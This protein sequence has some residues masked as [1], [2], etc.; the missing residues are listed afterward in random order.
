MKKLLLSALALGLATITNAQNPAFSWVNLI[1][2]D[3][4]HEE[5]ALDV[6]ITKSKNVITV[7]SIYQGADLNPGAGTFTSNNGSYY[8]QVVNSNGQFIWGTTFGH[9]SETFFGYN[10]TIDVDTLGNIY[11][12][13]NVKPGSYDLDFG[14][15]VTTYSTS[16][17]KSLFVAKY[18]SLGNLI[19]NQTC[20]ADVLAKSIAVSK[21]G[22]VAITG[23]YIGS[24]TLFGL[25]LTPSPNYNDGYV[26]LL[27]ANTG[28]CTAVNTWDD[29]GTEGGNDVIFDNV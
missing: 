28:S 13:A 22:K 11:L 26:A 5:I 12:A 17:N 1:G 25:T 24:P 3:E 20:N 21:N 14:A 9:L 27:D 15:G 8:I 6:A 18:D 2:T 19:W 29:G 23:N 10:V 7:G 16:V 4:Y